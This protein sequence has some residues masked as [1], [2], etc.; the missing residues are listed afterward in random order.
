LAIE[1]CQSYSELPKID[2]YE[3]HI[4]IVIHSITDINHD[5]RLEVS[6]LDIF[7]GK[8][9]IVTVHSNTVKAINLTKEKYNKNHILLSRGNDFL[10][11]TLLDVMVDNYFSLLDYWDERTEDIERRIL[12]NDITGI[13][14]E[15]IFIRRSIT[16]LRK[17]IAPQR[18]VINKLA[19]RDFPYISKEAG[20]YFRDIYDHILR[21]YEMLET[22]RDMINSAF[23]SYL[24]IFSNRLSEMSNNMNKVMQKLTIIATIFMPLTFIAGIYG[25]NFHIM[26]EIPWKYGYVYFWSLV[27]LIA[28]IMFFYFKKQ[29]WL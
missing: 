17:S 20:L 29:K 21:V 23:E 16:E 5:G 1:D 2:E 26:P 15:I 12:S 11:H 7:C 22:Y 14:E 27:V 3:N 13:L 6:E 9:Y 24:S 8:N 18:E 10:L 28:I 4:F 25:M 19:K